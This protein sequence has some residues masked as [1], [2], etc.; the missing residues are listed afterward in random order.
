MKN[1]RQYIEDDTHGQGCLLNGRCYRWERRP[2]DGN[3]F[4]RGAGLSRSRQ[5]GPRHPVWGLVA[6]WKARRGILE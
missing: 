3:Y 5:P 6:D 4:F 2:P 1:Q